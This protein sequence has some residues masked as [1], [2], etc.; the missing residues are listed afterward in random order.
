MGD[1]PRPESDVIGATRT[2]FGPS[3]RTLRLRVR[4][5]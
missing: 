2:L 3:G 1:F 4:E 5:G